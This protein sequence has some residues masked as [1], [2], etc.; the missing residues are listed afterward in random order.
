MKYLIYLPSQ[1]E[2][3]DLPEIA[4]Q[5]ICR[6]QAQGKP[7]WRIDHQIGQFS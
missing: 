7:L 3:A 1:Q 6:W 2:L 5:S 4:M